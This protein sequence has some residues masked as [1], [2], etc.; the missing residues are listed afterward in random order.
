MACLSLRVCNLGGRLDISHSLLRHRL[1]SCLLLSFL[2]AGTHIHKC[3]H[4]CTLVCSNTCVHVH[5]HV[6]IRSFSHL[7]MHTCIIILSYT[8]THPYCKHHTL[9][10]VHNTSEVFS[11]LG[12]HA[13]THSESLRLSSRSER[14]VWGERAPCPE[15]VKRFGD[16]AAAGGT[17]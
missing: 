7:R 13:Q 9:L 1:M 2:L 4:T 10:D 3:M 6:D 17:Q 5:M 16:S 12:I 11:L 15:G 8:H 14:G